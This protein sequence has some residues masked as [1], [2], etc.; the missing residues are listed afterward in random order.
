M[1]KV[2]EA[3]ALIAGDILGSISIQ[4]YIRMAKNMY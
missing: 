1:L 3:I 4:S 2:V